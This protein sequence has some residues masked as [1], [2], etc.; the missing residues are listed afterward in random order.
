M[1]NHNPSPNKPHNDAAD[2]RVSSAT[3]NTAC[4]KAIAKR[5]FSV[6]GA[7]ALVVGMVLAF[8][9]SQLL[10]IYLAGKLYLPNGDKLTTGELFYLGSSNGTIVSVSIA[11]SLVILSFLTVL[12]IRLRGGSISYY[13]AFRRFSMAVGIGMFGL[14]VLFMIASQALTYF[15]DKMPLVFVDPLYQSVSS[16]WLLILALVVIAPIYEEILFRGLFWSAIEEQFSAE[17]GVQG[18]VVAS[19]I[20]SFI[21]AIIHLQYGLYEIGTIV[22]LALIFSYARYKSGSLWLPILLHIINN[23][24]AMWQYLEQVN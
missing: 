23:G 14:L 19:F 5:L 21:F 17:S 9:G 20:T 10:G 3:I 6:P 1:S 24:L 11:F 13:L 16:V 4:N 8:F 22:I 15:L 18:A 12:I 2:N 7:V